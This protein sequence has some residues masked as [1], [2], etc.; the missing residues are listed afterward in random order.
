MALLEN[1]LRFMYYY[2]VFFLLYDEALKLYPIP[3]SPCI[4]VLMLTFFII[5]I[6][7]VITLTIFA[8]SDLFRHLK[9][10]EILF[11]K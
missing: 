4:Q 2:L 11:C 6:L 5:D 7:A 8:Y 10:Q 1:I 3:S 9:N